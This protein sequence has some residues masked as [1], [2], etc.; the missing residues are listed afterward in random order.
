M[1]LALVNPAH[2]TPSTC[3]RC[4]SKR[5]V[6]YGILSL[7]YQTIQRFL[8]RG[9]GKTFT[10]KD[11]RQ[12][13][14]PLRPILAALSAYNQGLTL[15]EAARETAKRYHTKIPLSTLHNWV[16]DYRSICTFARLRGSALKD[17]G[18]LILTRELFH[19]QLYLYQFHRA[20][21]ELQAGELGRDDHASLGGYLD[22]V[23]AETFPH[24]LFTPDA[25][26]ISQ[27]IFPLSDIRTFAKHNAANALASLALE[28]AQTTKERHQAVEDFFIANDSC[29]V[30]AEVPVYLTRDDIRRYNSRGFILGMTLSMPLTGHIDLLQVRNR[31]IR[32][33]DYKPDAA[34]QRPF[35][36]LTAYALALASRTGIPLE[37]FTCAWFDDRHYYEFFPGTS[38]TIGQR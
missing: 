7:K 24:G 34:R 36:Q 21:L 11:T 30:A 6:R 9:C 19:T 38:P 12:R 26:R 15:C 33:L 13:S 35:C 29:T 4:Y 31:R 20:K 1:E 3:P 14:Y 27:V 18:A 32:I 8:C 23:L 5:I 28:L 10:D 22:T 37:R 17:K 25:P 2:R 16:K